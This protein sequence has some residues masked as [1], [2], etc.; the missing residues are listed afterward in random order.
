MRILIDM[1]LTVRWAQH[2]VG[3]GHEATHWS[4][5]GDP[6]APDTRICEYARAHGFII[7]TNDLD[8]P[9]ILAQTGADG[10]SVALL[11]GE[12][13]TPEVRGVALLQALRNCQ[14]DLE[15]GAIVSLDWSGPPRAR[16]LPLK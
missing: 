1:N 15:S 8:F 2:L 10:P 9:H 12:P 11:R 7:L 6:R 13:L 16:V 14:S 5:V 3:A 4:T